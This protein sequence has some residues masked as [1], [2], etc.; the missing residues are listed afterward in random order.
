VANFIALS[1]NHKQRVDELAA[2][3][4]RIEIHIRRGEK[5]AAR[6]RLIGFYEEADALLAELELPLD[7]VLAGANVGLLS[8]KGSWLRGRLPATLLGATAGWLAGQASVA[9][10]RR[11]IGE[12]VMHSHSLHDVLAPQ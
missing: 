8:G 1:N 9:K 6:A 3:L 5:R 7:F 10:Q 11:F 12:L 2:R 4:A